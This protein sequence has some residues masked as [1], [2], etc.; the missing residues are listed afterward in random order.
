M[1]KPV[2]VWIVEDQQIEAI[3]AWRVILAVGDKFGATA[4]IHWADKFDWPPKL[5][6][7]PD[8]RATAITTAEYPDI[9][10]LDLC[11][12]TSKG[13]ILRANVLYSELR[14][15]ESHNPD[16]FPSF[17]I[18]WS[19]FRGRKDTDEFVK[20]ADGS[21]TRVILVDSKRSEVLEPIVENLWKRIIDDRE[22]A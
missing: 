14:K 19:I 12:Q 17:I 11:E 20:I 7:Q 18:F 6:A 16:G 3:E 1:S 21:D 22:N 13:E 5:R 2:N 15:W 9:V 4:V 10:V 8:P